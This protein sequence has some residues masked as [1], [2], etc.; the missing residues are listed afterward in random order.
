MKSLRNLSLF[1]VCA[2]TAGC[3]TPHELVQSGKVNV[4]AID[5]KTLRVPTPSIW[6]EGSDLVV[7]GTVSRKNSL[8]GMGPPEIYVTILGA[9][10]SV[11][12]QT[13]SPLHPWPIPHKGPRSSS[14]TA[15]IPWN[16]EEGQTVHVSLDK[17]E[18]HK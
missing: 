16:L 10:D 5:G 15:R 9:D 6:Q 18:V 8:S 4:I 12:T 13:K 7:S 1:L 11:L 14:Y 17:D 3:F 2:L